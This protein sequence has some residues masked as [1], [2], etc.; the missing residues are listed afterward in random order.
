MPVTML[1]LTRQWHNLGGNQNANVFQNPDPQLEDQSQQ[2]I[3]MV[4]QTHP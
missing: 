4:A 3:R 1:V 2:L